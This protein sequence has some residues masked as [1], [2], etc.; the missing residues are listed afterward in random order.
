MTKVSYVTSFDDNYNHL[1]KFDFDKILNK[2][3]NLKLKDIDLND[4]NKMID[5]I[6]FV[7]ICNYKV[8]LNHLENEVDFY[9]KNLDLIALK[10]E[11]TLSKYYQFNNE[12]IQMIFQSDLAAF[13]L[14]K[15][16]TTNNLEI[17]IIYDDLYIYENCTGDVYLSNSPDINYEICDICGDYDIKLG[18]VNTSHELID[19]LKEY[20]YSGNMIN[21]IQTEYYTWF[22][23]NEV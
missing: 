10:N 9:L 13:C 7:D 12:Y 14:T 6:T 23:K 5:I 1:K 20:N 22:N 16:L 4:T 18:Q 21:Q 2:L 3:N 19:L 8:D 15:Y 11:F 17:E